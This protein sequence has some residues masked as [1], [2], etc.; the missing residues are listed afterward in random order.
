MRAIR[1]E[2]ALRG[3]RRSIAA[4]AVVL[5]FGGIVAAEHSGAGEMHMPQVAAWCLAV[6]P[7]AL[8]L[9]A[10]NGFSS[11]AAL[12]WVLVRI[13][14]PLA[15]DPTTTSARASPVGRMVLRL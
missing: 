10:R 9:A 14:L 13:R 7:G 11:P 1:L 15:L 8:L 4:V 6:L 3:R 5:A 12:P 2:S